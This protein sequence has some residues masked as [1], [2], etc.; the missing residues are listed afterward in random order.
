[1]RASRACL[2]LALLA[3][4]LC[5]P[6]PGWTQSADSSHVV[7]TDSATADTPSS[8]CMEI[9]LREAAHLNRE[10]MARYS[11]LTG[12]RSRGISRRLIWTERLAIPVAWYV[13]WRARRFLRAGIR[14][15]CD[16]FVPMAHTPAFRE[17]NADPPPFSSFRPSDPRRIRRTIDGAYRSGGF[18]A[19]S[20]AI[21]REIEHLQGT[22][23]FHCMMRHLLESALRISNQASVYEAQARERGL[24]SPAGVSRLMLNLHLSTLGEAAKLD[25]RAAPLQAEG[26][27]IICQDVPPIPPRADS[28]HSHP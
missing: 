26:I 11:T 10:R 19:A 9:H 5:V 13:D 7:A 28:S 4:A 20:T 14:V 8:R 16:D 25:R 23:A 2:C 1:M 15:T 24:R 27:P 12:G 22:P 6:A 21:E 17:R 18:P 3:A